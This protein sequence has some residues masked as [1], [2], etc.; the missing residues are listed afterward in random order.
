MTRTLLVPLAAATE[1]VAVGVVSVA[2]VAVGMVGVRAAV[3]PSRKHTLFKKE[4]GDEGWRKGGRE[5]WFECL[6]VI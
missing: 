5:G 4:G 1:A 6:T 3:P 2:G